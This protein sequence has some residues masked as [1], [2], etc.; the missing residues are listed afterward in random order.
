[1]QSN[2]A[3]KTFLIIIFLSIYS[4]GFI[5]KEK[6]AN[7]STFSPAFNEETAY[8]YIINQLKFG[9]RIP[10]SKAHQQ[11]QLM[12]QRHFMNLGYLVKSEKS[13]KQAGK[14]LITINNLM[15]SYKVDNPKKRILLATH[16]D[17]RYLSNDSIPVPV[18]GANDGASGTSVLMEI[19]NVLKLDSVEYD[20]DFV[21]FDGQDQGSD[22]Y[23]KTWNLGAQ[24]WA[25]SNKVSYDY[26][27]VID[28]VGA[29]DA[30]FVKEKFSSYFCEDLQNKIWSIGDKL[31]YSNYFSK[32]NTVEQLV[33]DHY[34]INN[35]SKSKVPTLLITDYRAKTNSYFPQWHTKDDV[36]EY[37]HKPTL[38]AVGQT[39]VELLYLKD[40]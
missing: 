23:P 35:Y 25:K 15:A 8:D 16:Y 5:N 7:I 31:N 11:C 36:I 1:M 20:I 33:N 9:N 13:I 6:D 3:F 10:E 28:M 37:I 29:K 34:F 32:E 26:G 30:Q 18:P 27:I 22:A 21:F 24:K 19:A 14:G 2:Y 38:K 12:I 39:M 17:T 40:K 4:C